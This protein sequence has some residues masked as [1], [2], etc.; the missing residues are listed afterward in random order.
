MI[1]KFRAYFEK[2]KRMIEGIGLINQN[3][4]LV[5]FNDQGNME[6][7]FLSNGICLTQ[8][9]G[10]IDKNGKEIFEGDIIKPLGFASWIGVVEY[11]KE[12]A[13]YI[14]NAHD[15]EFSRSEVVYLSQFNDGLEILGN[16]YEN[17]ELLKE[18]E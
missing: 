17:P 9:T 5:D 13:A 15:N 11:S 6:P 1:S 7:I 8:S 14:L 4:I 2:Y 18:S 16:I 12:N 10:M 3:T